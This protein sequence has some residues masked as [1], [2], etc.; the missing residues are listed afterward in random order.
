MNKDTKSD[1]FEDIVEII[2][3][4][5]EDHILETHKFCTI[6]DI[7][8]KTG[9]SRSI[10]ERALECLLSQDKIY[11]AY[12]REGVP[13]IYIPKYMM[14]EILSKQSKPKWLKNYRFEIRNEIDAK[15]QELKNQL[16]RYEMFERLLYATGEPL[17][18]AVY[19]T[20][21]WLGIKNVRYHKGRDKDIQDIDFEIDDTKYLIEVK[22]KAGLA[23]KDDVEELNGWRKQEVLKEENE[24]KC[25]EGILIVNHQRKID[26]EQRKEVLTNHAKKWL[27]MYHLKVFTTYSLFKLI[28]DVEARRLS[29][30]KAI[31][32][33][34]QG[35]KV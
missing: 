19:F 25:I 10:C 16:F 35:E 34:I 15:I 4:A 20:L 22:G 13:K 30:K 24:G 14:E 28:R 9:K 6:R 33:I 21:K 29:K 3:N 17:E 27:E 7:I 23:D 1:N 32:I 12:E 8:Q 11:V 26:P 2:Y 5:I 18:E 31:N